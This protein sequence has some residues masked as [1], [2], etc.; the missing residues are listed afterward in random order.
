MISNLDRSLG[1]RYFLYVMNERTDFVSRA[2]A[3]EG[4]TLVIGLKWT[5]D[6]KVTLPVFLPRLNEINGPYKKIFSVTES[7]WSNLKFLRMRDL[8][9]WLWGWNVR[10][11][12]L[13]S[14]FPSVPFV[15]LTLDQ[16]VGCGGGLLERQRRDSHVYRK[17]G[18]AS[19]YY[20]N[21]EVWETVK[22]VG[23]SWRVMDA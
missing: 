16:F 3:L 4:F 11:N 1:S 18:I 22:K 12:G 8:N 23:N 19:D 20:I 15:V 2:N 13:R 21:D 6:H 14:V 9:A 7:F 5:S 10:V 17:T